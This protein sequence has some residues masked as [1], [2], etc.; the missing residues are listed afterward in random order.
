[1]HPLVRLYLKTAFVFLALG[2]LTGLWIEGQLVFGGRWLSHAMVVAHVHLL[3]VGFLLLLILGVAL[4][5]F[6][7]L[8]RGQPVGPNPRLAAVGYAC[9]ALGTVGRA[10]TEFLDLW[11][12]APGWQYARFAFAALQ[13]AGIGLGIAL[14]WRRVRGAAVLKPDGTV[15]LTG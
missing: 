13:V 4:W 3:L 7:R 15:S 10:A 8:A 5:M 2:L 6:P 1:M 11:L 14:V 12:T 9:L